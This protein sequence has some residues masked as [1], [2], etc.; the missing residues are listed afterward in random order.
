[1]LKKTQSK[2]AFY[3]EICSKGVRKN[4]TFFGLVLKY[5]ICTTKANISKH[6]CAILRCNQRF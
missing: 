2:D 6:F 5:A 3:N 4:K 1:M